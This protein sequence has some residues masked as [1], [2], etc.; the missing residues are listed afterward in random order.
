MRVPVIYAKK[1]SDIY[2]FGDEIDSGT[3]GRVMN[4]TSN[5]SSEQIVCKIVERNGDYLRELDH[6]ISLNSCQGVLPLKRAVITHSELCFEFEKADASLY[7][8]IKQR[9]KTEKPIKELLRETLS[10]TRQLFYGLAEIHYNGIIH[11]DI[12]SS[13]VVIMKHDKAVKAWLIDLGMSKR[14]KID[15]SA[16]ESCYEI[17]TT[18]YRAPELWRPNKFDNRQDARFYDEKV[19][20]WSVGCIIYEMIA[21]KSPF[22]ANDNQNLRRRIAGHL[23]HS[24][25]VYPES[26]WNEDDVKPVDLEKELDDIILSH[27]S[28]VA[29]H[30]RSRSRDD[31]PTNVVIKSLENYSQDDIE[32]GDAETKLMFYVIKKLMRISLKPRPQDRPSAF[33]CLQILNKYLVRPKQF[34]APE[35][36]VV[37][38]R[39][40]ELNKAQQLEVMQLLETLYAVSDQL[41]HNPQIV[42]LAVFLWLRCLAVNV[43]IKNFEFVILLTACLQIS[44]NYYNGFSKKNYGV[45]RAMIGSKFQ[46]SPDPPEIVVI[47]AILGTLDGIWVFNPGEIRHK[48]NNSENGWCENDLKLFSS[49]MIFIEHML[50]LNPVVPVVEPKQLTYDI[51]N[52]TENLEKM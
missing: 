18:P 2:I 32:L 31:T 52:N 46:D 16:S 51:L 23:L 14:S 42:F 33:S 45:K 13:N 10:I 25:G 9:G 5:V 47:A 19:D 11:R 3:Y 15:A 44:C 12:K 40:P 49:M 8:Y 41:K 6:L 37:M 4:A 1:L 43:L 27:K 38:L 30:R 48:M 26:V 29:A 36:K 20:V 34:I 17:V 24:C 7:N 50:K 28:F 21:G 35:I 22:R 39:I